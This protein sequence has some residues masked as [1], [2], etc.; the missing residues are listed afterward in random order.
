MWYH[1]Q[2]HSLSSIQQIQRRWV[3]G[4]SVPFH[5]SPLSDFEKT[6][7]LKIQYLVCETE[8]QNCMIRICK[9]CPSNFVGIQRVVK[10]SLQDCN[11]GSIIQFLQ[12]TTTDCSTMVIQQESV[13]DYIDLIVRNLEKIIPHS[14]IA[15]AQAKHLKERKQYSEEE[16]ALLLGDFAENYRFVIKDEVQGFHCNNSQCTLYPVVIYCIEEGSLIHRSNCI[17][18]D[19]INHGIAFVHLVQKAVI[20]DLMYRIPRLKIIEYFSDG[21][22]AQYKNRNNFLNLCMHKKDFKVSAKWNFFTTSH[23]RQ[24]CDG[25]VGTVKH[26][27]AKASLQCN[28]SNHILNAHT[29]FEV[30]RGNIQHIMFFFVAKDEV[31]EARQRMEK[32]FAGTKAVPGTQSFHQFEPISETKIGARRCSKDIQ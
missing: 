30:C 27:V 16:T 1:H 12:W 7:V 31:L 20:N 13:E 2:Y 3:L 8:N 5:L 26:L 21:C 19:D 6:N 11:E 14:Y 4:A 29:M 24:H 17:I 25:I 22:G 9:D 18:S 28:I 23:G 10:E 32:R 15:K